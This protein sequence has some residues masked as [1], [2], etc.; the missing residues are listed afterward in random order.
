MQKVK[1]RYVKN[2][3]VEKVKPNFAEIL[4]RSK[5]AVYV[6]EE[7]PVIPPTVTE[8]EKTESETTENNS[9]ENPETESTETEQ[10][11]DEST[12]QNEAPAV[13]TRSRRGG[14]GNR[15]SEAVKTS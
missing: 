4:V 12:D 2:N 15:N 6:T 1:I 11:N 5:I 9:T 14:R 7:E 10:T 8:T 3:K 13:A